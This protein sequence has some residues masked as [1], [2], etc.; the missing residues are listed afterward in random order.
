MQTMF[1]SL[2]KSCAFLFLL[3]SAFNIKFSTAQ[4]QTTTQVVATTSIRN[5]L[6]SECSMLSDRY[7]YAR[8]AFNYFLNGPVRVNSTPFYDVIPDDQTVSEMILF[9]MQQGSLGLENSKPPP[10]I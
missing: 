7:C 1:K 2:A 6:S 10:G 9:A 8:E 5:A 4:A 3:V